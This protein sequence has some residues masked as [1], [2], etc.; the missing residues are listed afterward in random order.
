MGFVKAGVHEEGDAAAHWTD[1]EANEPTPQVGCIA[2]LLV[3]YGGHIH[4]AAW[5]LNV[6]WEVEVLSPK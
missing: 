5:T 1:A 3:D 6:D 2:A 4:L